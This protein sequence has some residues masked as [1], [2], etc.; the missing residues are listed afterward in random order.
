MLKHYKSGPRLSQAAAYNGTL[1]I[2]GQVAEDRKAGIVEQTRDVLAKID[3][4]LAAAGAKR[5]HLLS[6][7]VYLPNIADFDAMNSVYDPWISSPTPPPRA[8]VEARLADPDLRVEISAISAIPA[9]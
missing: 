2:A 6:V 5:E 1:Y 7:T 9:N 4:L 8:C 3:D